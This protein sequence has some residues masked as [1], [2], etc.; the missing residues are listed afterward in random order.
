M[1]PQLLADIVGEVAEVNPNVAPGPSGEIFPADLLKLLRQVGDRPVGVEGLPEAPVDLCRRWVD[2]KRLSLALVE[3]RL[4]LRIFA[5]AL[6]LGDPRLS[7][8]RECNFISVLLNYEADRRPRT[9]WDIE[10]RGLAAA[11]SLSVPMT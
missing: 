10:A 4:G 1:L 2:Q 7:L 3:P 5:L 9:L 11:R 8:R 6:A